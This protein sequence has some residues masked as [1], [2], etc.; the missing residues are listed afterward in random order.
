MK[1]KKK[2][3]KLSIFGAMSFLILGLIS[4]NSFAS[5]NHEHSK[6]KEMIRKSLTEESKKNLIAVMKANEDLHGAF[7]KYDGKKIEKSAIKLKS[8][9]EALKDTEI[10]KLLKFS[11]TKLGEITSSNDR[12]ANNNAYHIVS[13]ALIH[14]INKY[15]LGS[16]YNAY[17]CPMVR[18]KWV[19]NSKK[20]EEVHNPYAPNMPHCGGQDT[21]Y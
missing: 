9:I 14:I 5:G 6:S 13:S 1:E 11:V 18:K 20:M 7:F 2:T 15:D 12:D 10:S 19:Q 4:F 17:S 16:Q 8:K 21:E 3:S